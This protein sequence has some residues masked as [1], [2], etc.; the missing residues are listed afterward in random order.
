MAFVGLVVTLLGF[1]IAVLSLGITQSVGA[2]LGIV[3]LGLAVSLFGIIG[4][5]NPAYLK[6][7]IW[8]KG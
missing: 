3:L 8:R 5:L 4:L 7:V 6:T 2:R 1:V